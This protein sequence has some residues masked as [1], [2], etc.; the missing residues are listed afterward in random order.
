MNRYDRMSTIF[1]LVLATAICVESIRVGL[2]S[3]SNPGPGLLPLGCG[4][5]LGILSLIVFARTF[6]KS[7]AVRAI[8]WEPGTRWRNL[9]LAI[10]SLIGYAFLIELLGFYFITFVWASFVCRWVG[11]MRWKTT[12]ITSV[13]AT[14]S[15]YLLFEQ[16]LNVRFPKGIWGL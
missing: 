5:I 15:S 9:F 14:A 1:F 7:E 13:V 11:R 10:F 3:L 2:G 4:L 12:L 6:K 16:F 8:L